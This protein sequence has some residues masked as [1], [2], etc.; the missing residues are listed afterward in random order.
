M[1]SIKWIVGLEKVIAGH[2][3]ERRRN[4]IAE[5]RTEEKRTRKTRVRFGKIQEGKVV[6]KRVVKKKSN[7]P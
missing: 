6:G 5:K 1:S 2:E 4:C 3:S 7:V